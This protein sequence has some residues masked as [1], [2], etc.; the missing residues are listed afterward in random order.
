MINELLLR[1]EYEGSTYDLIVDNE[2]PLR[3]DMSAVESQD[4]GKFFGIGSQTFNL[5]GTKDTNRFFNY[6]YDVSTDDVPGFY[7]TL[8]CSVILNGETVLIGSL[9]L[10]SVITNDEGYVTYQVQVV[11]KVLQFE[12]LLAS[13]LIKDA[14]WSAYTHTLTSQSI[15]ESWSDNLLG[16][17]VFYPLA[18]YGRTNEDTYPAIPRVQFA[19]S[20]S[21]GG[22][23][24]NRFVTPMQPQQFLPAIKLKDTLDVVFDQVGFT[25]TGSFV[26]TDDFNNLYVLPK[27][28]EAEGPVVAGSEEGIFS[29]FA[30]T[31]QTFNYNVETKVNANAESNDPL[32]LYN[33]TTSTYT[34]GTIGRH[35]FTGQIGFTN[36]T[37]GDPLTTSRVTLLLKSGSTTIDSIYSDFQSSD[38]IGPFYLS[39]G[40]SKDLQVGDEITLAVLYQIVVSSGSP[41]TVMTLLQNGTQFNCTSAAVNFNGVTIDMGL[42]WQ[43]ATKSIDFIRGLLQQF[44]L[45]MTPE[46]G[47]KSVIKIEQFDEWIR[48]GEIK[49]WTSKY[50]TA[51]RIKITHTVDELEREVL[52]KSADDTDRFSRVALE[53]EPNYQYG[54][55]RLLADNTISQGEKIIGDYFAPTV[56]GGPLIYNQSGSDNSYTFNIDLN[57]RNVYPHLYKLENNA[58]KAYMFKPRLGY[59]VTNTLQTGDSIC[60]GLPDLLGSN[61][62]LT[63]VSGS[64]STLSNLS[65][66]PAVSG[67]SNDLHF[68]NTYGPFT[69]A[70]LNLNEGVSA[71]DSYWKTYLDSL[72][73]EGAKKIELDLFFNE[74]EYKDIQ[75]NDRILI[76]GQAYRINKISGFNISHRDVVTVELIRL[77]PA[78]W[79]L[80]PV[81]PPAPSVY[82]SLN[83]CED[84]VSGFRSGQTTAELPGL[85]TSDRVTA[86]GVTYI[87]TGT[88]IA[89]TSVGTIFDTGETSCPATQRYYNYEDCATGTT[90]TGVALWPSGS[91]LDNGNSFFNSECFRITT[92][93][94]GPNFG[95]FDLTGYTIYNDCTDCNTA[96]P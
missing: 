42:Q 94:T 53:Q 93:T 2:V 36:P 79:S 35:Q 47:N 92:E 31:N 14:N 18:E 12:E 1:V 76:K 54:T 25:Y 11:D 49:D 70:G 40:A 44:N 46:V 75:L 20:G 95:D 34:V 82:Y 91:T 50:D 90:I 48:A 58:Q 61:T 57:S 69:G 5:P 7:N 63:E 60:I 22:G 43:P 65:T 17:S 33:T 84:N 38:G 86:S 68:N 6:A 29:A 27:G 78:Y 64:Y 32:G 15:I 89:G 73:W 39:V 3:I 80:E 81:T 56:L 74:Y 41:S 51:K 9:Q 23:A 59:K 88:T 62:T 83:R 67:S 28:Q 87:V 55:L 77:Y 21:A 66:L 96:N 85:G 72:Y 45:V 8:D 16:G 10:V 26:E 30:I 71:F 52:L 4:L 24:V 37:A 19:P 13:K